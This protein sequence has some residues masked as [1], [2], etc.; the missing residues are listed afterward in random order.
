MILVFII[1][2]IYSVNLSKL[3]NEKSALSDLVDERNVEIL[4]GQDSVDALE[5]KLQSMKQEMKQGKSLSEART[6]NVL[7]NFDKLWKSLGLVC[8][9]SWLSSFL[10]LVRNPT[11]LFILKLCGKHDKPSD[12]NETKLV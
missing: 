10:T 8:K 9:P 1:F 5:Q 7:L 12:S 2:L 3:E 4:K 11:D 6:R